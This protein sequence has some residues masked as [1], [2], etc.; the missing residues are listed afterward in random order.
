MLKDTQLKRDVSTT[1]LACLPSLALLSLKLGS[2]LGKM[3]RDLG[4]PQ[5]LWVLCLYIGLSGGCWPG[6]GRPSVFASCSP[7]YR[8]L[9]A[10][11]PRRDSYPTVST[12]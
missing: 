10:V 7:F 8:Y 11:D 12:F 5:L 2:I 9:P 6:K 4:G 3:E 1:V